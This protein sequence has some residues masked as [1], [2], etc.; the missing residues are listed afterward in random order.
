MTEQTR[1]TAHAP[2]PV[3]IALAGALAIAAA[4]CSDEPGGGTTMPPP[5]IDPEL[6]T[7]PPTR[8]SLVA[9]GGFASPADAV[10]SPDGSTFFF[11]AYTTGVPARAA[12]FRVAS[13]GG[14]AEPMHAGAPLGYPTGLVMSCDGATLFV[15]D[16]GIASMPSEPD[17]DEELAGVEG[18]DGGL[19]TIATAG[20]APERLAADGIAIPSG[21]AMGPDCATLYVT[22]WNADGEP[23]LFSVPA[24]GGA[25][26]T[27]HAGAPLRSPTGVH[28][29]ADRVAWVMDHLAGNEQGEGVLFAITEDGETTPVIGGLRMGTP[30]GVSLV[31]GGGTA[32]IPTRDEAGDGQLI[33]VHIATGEMTVVPAPDMEDPAGLRTAR[34]A[35]VFAVV[36]SEGSAIWRAE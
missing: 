12:V 19:Y 7:E 35:G 2:R 5:T 10:A 6:P 8:L 32:V 25:A 1:R 18:P 23:A 22:G 30:G 3:S 26:R 21:L 11:T 27:I 4:A 9:Q 20:G 34:S 33:T 36:D 15:A 28:V 31:A 13:S 17:A 24:T 14:T 29:D 16:Q